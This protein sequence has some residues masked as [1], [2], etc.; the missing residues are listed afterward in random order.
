M[1]WKREDVFVGSGGGEGVFVGG[2]E[3]V[4]VRCLHLRQVRSS[5]KER[6]VGEEWKRLGIGSL[7]GG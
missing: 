7:L 2:G 3:G 4:C 5:G 6:G 1:E